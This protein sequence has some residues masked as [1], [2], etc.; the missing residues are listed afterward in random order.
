MYHLRD[1]AVGR[2]RAI[3]PVEPRQEGLPGIR[4]NEIVRHLDH[5][6]RYGFNLC[7]RGKR[8]IYVAFG[9]ALQKDKKEWREKREWVGKYLTQAETNMM[10]LSQG[11]IYVFF[12]GLSLSR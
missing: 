12:P 6:S 5:H 4:G 7:T 10:I 11:Y 2:I 3:K 8:G 1:K 9:S